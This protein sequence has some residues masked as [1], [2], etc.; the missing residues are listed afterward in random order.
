LSVAFG[1]LRLGERLVTT[2]DDPGLP[3]IIEELLGSIGPDLQLTRQM[4]HHLTPGCLTRTGELLSK[5]IC[6]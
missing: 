6:E 2:H 5:A 4:M 1:K 3:E